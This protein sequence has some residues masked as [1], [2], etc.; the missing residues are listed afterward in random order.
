MELQQH[1]HMPHIQTR[2]R[3]HE[4][5]KE[6]LGPPAGAVTVAGLGLYPSRF[7]RLCLAQE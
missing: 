5:P 2:E 1:P 3:S 7:W 4:V 6:P